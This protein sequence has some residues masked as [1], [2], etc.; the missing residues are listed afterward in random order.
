MPEMYRFPKI[1]TRDVHF[2]EACIF[3]EH[4]DGVTYTIPY[5]PLMTINEVRNQLAEKSGLLIDEKTQYLMIKCYKALYDRTR[6]L[7]QY[8]I[9]ANNTLTIMVRGC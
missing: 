3:V 8:G 7:A 6:T 4:A 9:Q 2:L 1:K 5:S